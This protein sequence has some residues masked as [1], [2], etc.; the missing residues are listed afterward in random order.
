M[1]S[2][3]MTARKRYDPLKRAFVLDSRSRSFWIA[4]SD[5]GPGPPPESSLERRP[6]DRRRQ[7][8]D[9]DLRRAG[10]ALVRPASD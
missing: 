6:P 5:A 1:V 9:D 2:S 8:I 3:P 7:M 4:G 10:V